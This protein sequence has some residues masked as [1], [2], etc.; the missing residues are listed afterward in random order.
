MSDEKNK[1][2]KTTQVMRVVIG[3]IFLL[4]MAL[5]V[6]SFVFGHSSGSKPASNNYEPRN[7]ESPF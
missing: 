3:I 7:V 4:V 1:P 2:E 6:L 5:S